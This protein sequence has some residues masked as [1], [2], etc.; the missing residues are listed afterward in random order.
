MAQLL[1]RRIEHSLVRKLKERAGKHGVSMEE[2]HRRI[3]RDVLL[4]KKSKR[5]PLKDYL[6]LMPDPGPDT[7]FERISDTGRKIEM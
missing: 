2:E 6:F 1:V 5:L 4:G 3:L 7:L